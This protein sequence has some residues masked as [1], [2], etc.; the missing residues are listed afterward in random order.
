MLNIKK[1]SL[2][3]LL[4]PLI[5][6]KPN[7]YKNL[8]IQNRILD[9][10][11][12][13]NYIYIP[14]FNIKRVIINNTDNKTLD[15]YYVGKMNINV[16]NLTILAGH[17]INSVFHKIHY[18]NVNDVV[19]LKEEK[20]K[21]IDHKEIKVDDYSILNTKYECPTLILMTCTNDKNKR[22]IVILNNVKLCQM[23]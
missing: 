23:E 4:I 19:Y 15:N 1:S 8:Y 7:K 10:H 16:D 12:E 18:L 6:I 17:N 2:I 21:V 3:L 9:S 22:Y 13:V 11:K 5:F 14:R 20:Y